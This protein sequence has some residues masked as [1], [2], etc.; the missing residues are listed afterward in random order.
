SS[1]S[2]AAL[3]RSASARLCSRKAGIRSLRSGSTR[4]IVFNSYS[5]DIGAAGV[6]RVSFRRTGLDYVADGFDQ[7]GLAHRFGDVRVTSGREALAHGFV[8]RGG[9]QGDDRQR[10]APLLALPSANRADRRVT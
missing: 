5:A 4:T 10:L 8:Q 2:A 1:L 9:G 3:M 7:R 6:R